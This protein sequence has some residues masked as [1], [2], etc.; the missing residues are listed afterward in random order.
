MTAIT[1]TDFDYIRAL[2]REEAAIVLEPGKEYLAENRLQPVARAAGLATLED[3]VSELRTGPDELR[4]QVVDAL[5]TNET[6]F[7]R[8]AHPWEALADEVIPELIAAR[9][10]D[11]ALRFWC[12]AASSGQEPYSLAMLMRDRFASQLAGWD[13]QILATDLSPSMIDRAGTGS[14]SQ[15]EVNRGLPAATLV[16]HFTRQGLRWQISEKIRDAVDFR[17]MNLADE[18]DY[19]RLGPFDLILIRNV[20]IY[21]DMDT[22]RDIL[23]RCRRILRPDGLLFLGTSETTINVVDDYQRAVYGKTTCYRPT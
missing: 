9:A 14:F 5:T 15:L 18:H 8:D 13:V 20:L 4:A 3:L 17:L 6:S 16:E 10:D 11:R 19:D 23:R 1:A 21:F 7:F 2:V 12:A 22:K